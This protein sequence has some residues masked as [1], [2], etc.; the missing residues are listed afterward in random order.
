MAGGSEGRRKSLKPTGKL[1]ALHRRTY[2]QGT[3]TT[4]AQTGFRNYEALKI[5]RRLG[6][7]EGGLT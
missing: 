4:H 2:D 1:D 5:Q 6:E 3:E 7:T